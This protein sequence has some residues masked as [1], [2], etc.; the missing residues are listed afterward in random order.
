MLKLITKKIML[1]KPKSKLKNIRKQK[2]TQEVFAEL[3]ALSQSQYN[4]REKG[5]LAISEEEW[6]R[7]AKVLEVDVELIKEIDTPVINITHNHGENDNSINGYEITIKLPKN[8]LDVFHN[9]L[10]TLITLISKESIVFFWKHLFIILNLK[11]F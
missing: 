5:R 10:D 8:I 1:Y 2:Y 3:V 9:K 6:N 7:F 4:R 11:S